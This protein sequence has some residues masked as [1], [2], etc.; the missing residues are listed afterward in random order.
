MRRFF[1]MFISTASTTRA[2][3]CIHDFSVFYLH[4]FFC[5][6]FVGAEAA[7][8]TKK[9]YRKLHTRLKLGKSVQ[10]RCTSMVASKKWIFGEQHFGA[11]YFPFGFFTFFVFF[12][13]VFF[14]SIDFFSFFSCF[15]HGKFEYL[16]LVIGAI[17]NSAAFPKIVVSSSQAKKLEKFIEN[18]RTS[19]V[20]F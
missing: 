16:N 8:T 2:T 10:N 7:T 9:W 12:L 13:F 3:E 20:L 5:R 14:S 15:L 18:I 11:S 4:F 19:F 6:D 1:C 17:K